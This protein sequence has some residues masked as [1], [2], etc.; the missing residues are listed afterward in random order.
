MYCISLLNLIRF[1][2]AIMLSVLRYMAPHYP[3]GMLK[4]Y[5]LRMGIR[6]C[7]LKDRQ[8]DDQMG[9]DKKTDNTMTKWEG[10]KRQTIR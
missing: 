2:L 9:R 8:Y 10:T 1:H 6:N 4:K 7:K 5:R 3:Y